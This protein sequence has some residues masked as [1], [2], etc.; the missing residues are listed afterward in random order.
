[1]PNAGRVRAKYGF[2]DRGRLKRKCS[3]KKTVWRINVIRW[4]RFKVA[5]FREARDLAAFWDPNPVRLTGSQAKFEDNIPV[6]LCRRSYL[7][8]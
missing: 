6:P 8:E 5:V 7:C 2:K 3:S 4:V 1:M